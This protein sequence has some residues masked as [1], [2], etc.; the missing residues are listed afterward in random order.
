MTT[1]ELQQSATTWLASSLRRPTGVTIGGCW[2]VA[3]ADEAVVRQRPDDPLGDQVAAAP[4]AI[5]A[6]EVERVLGG[7][8]DEVGELGHDSALVDAAAFENLGDVG[9]AC[10]VGHG[11][12]PAKGLTASSKRPKGSTFCER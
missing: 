4:G 11:S 5:V 9:V 1:S 3:C 2:L 10:A 7:E 8:P 6:T 12:S